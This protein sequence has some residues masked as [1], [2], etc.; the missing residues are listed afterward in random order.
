MKR[1]P[2]DGDHFVLLQLRAYVEFLDP[3][4]LAV[5]STLAFW[6]WVD[7]QTGLGPDG[8]AKL[9]RMSTGKAKMVLTDLLKRGWVIKENGRR[10]LGERTRYR[11][12][13]DPMTWKEARTW[14]GVQLPGAQTVGDGPATTWPDGGHDVAGRVGASSHQVDGPILKKDLRERVKREREN[15]ANIVAPYLE[16]FG[17]AWTAK[18]GEAWL[19]TKGPQGQTDQDQVYDLVLQGVELSAFK[20]KLP[21]FF[22]HAG[23]Y[24]K[25]KR[26]PLWLM[27]RTWNELPSQEPGKQK[28]AGPELEL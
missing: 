21:A 15:R 18:T 4:E 1:K 12:S 19:P 11:L 17:Q 3:F 27:I 8:V 23:D 28:K 7:P 10:D 2:T 24:H 13:L 26:W 20:A 6:D 25:T 16:A 5:V 22:D 9:G 14:A